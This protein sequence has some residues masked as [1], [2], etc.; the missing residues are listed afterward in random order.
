MDTSYIKLLTSLSC[1]INSLYMKAHSFLNAALLLLVVALMSYYRAEHEEL[2]CHKN[3]GRTVLIEHCW[4][5]LY[6][7][8][9]MSTDRI[10]M[11]LWMVGY[12]AMWGQA[13]AL[14]LPYLGWFLYDRGTLLKSTEGI[15]DDP[16]QVAD[17]FITTYGGNGKYVFVFNALE[18]L[19]LILV[20][21]TLLVTAFIFRLG[22]ADIVPILMGNEPSILDTIFPD[23]GMCTDSTTSHIPNLPDVHHYECLLHLSWVRRL[24]FSFNAW[25]L[26]ILW[27]WGVLQ[28]VKT[29][30]FCTIKQLRVYRFRLQGGKLG[31]KTKLGQVA[32]EM[33]YA[34]FVVALALG[35]QLT[36]G[37]FN[38]FVE[39]LYREV[40]AGHDGIIH[41]MV[42]NELAA[43]SDS[44]ADWDTM[45]MSQLAQA[46]EGKAD[47]DGLNGEE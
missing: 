10:E 9:T 24:I 39:R 27:C 45:Q 17:F 44:D 18:T 46:E 7:P 12:P 14:F 4:K 11:D 25:W 26:V 3:S 23:I 16:G 32:T 28:L 30:A 37:N 5:N 6:K 34:D 31:A 33:D 29:V 47:R 35:D 2:V 43:D 15:R 21:A 22:L 38:K 40:C 41:S 20:T 1:S 13:I 19:N 36:T 42:D 8:G